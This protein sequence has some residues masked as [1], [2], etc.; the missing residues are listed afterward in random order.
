MNVRERRRHMLARNQMVSAVVGVLAAWLVWAAPAFA[1]WGSPELVGSGSLN[2]PLGLAV[3]GSTGNLYVANIR[4]AG[5][6]KFDLAHNL[7]SPPSPFGG[8]EVFSGLTLNVAN[9]RVYVVNA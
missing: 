4:R 1:G 9:S 2:N 7:L 3:E 6:D 5:N 8:K